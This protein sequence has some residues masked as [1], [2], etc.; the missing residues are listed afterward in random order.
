[1]I[2]LAEAFMLAL[3]TL[4]VMLCVVTGVNLQNNITMI[5]M[6]NDYPNSMPNMVLVILIPMIFLTLIYHRI[7]INDK[8]L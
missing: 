1:M 3:C 7:L 2:M 5:P 6:V 4:V 8:E